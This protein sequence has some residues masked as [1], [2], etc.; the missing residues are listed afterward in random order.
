MT[1]YALEENT[2]GRH[3]TVEIPLR[4]DASTGEGTRLPTTLPPFIPADQLYYWTRVWQ[5]GEAKAIADIA[6]GRSRVFSD[7]RELARYLLRPAD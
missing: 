4:S 1:T 5:E 2:Q 3:A 6:A 7:P